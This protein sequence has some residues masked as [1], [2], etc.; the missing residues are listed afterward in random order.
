MSDETST[1]TSADPTTSISGENDTVVAEAASNYSLAVSNGPRGHLARIRCVAS[2]PVPPEVIYAVL[3]NPDNAGVFR[4]VADCSSRKLLIEEKEPQNA[5]LRVVE[6]EQLGKVRL[7]G[8]E[9]LFRTKLR[10][11]E[12]ARAGPGRLSTRFELLRSDVLS[13]F[14]GTWTL[15]PFEEEGGGSGDCVMITTRA[16]LE[17]DVTPKGVPRWLKFVPLAGGAVK[18]AC[19]GAVRRMV[20]DLAAVADAVF[21]EGKSLESVLED[22]R[23][24]AKEGKEGKE[25]GEKKEA[26]VAAA[27]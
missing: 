19:A 14:D 16:T 23:R 26:E 6:V 25:E 17:Q 8:R 9:V 1:S 2:F 10:V 4:D 15:E 3:T 11:T 13:T 12:D 27:G 24:R 20:E 21:R 5:L 22:C 18:R 7:L